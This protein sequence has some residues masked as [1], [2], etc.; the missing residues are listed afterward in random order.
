MLV[1]LF[2]APC[3]SYSRMDMFFLLYP[4]LAKPGI[5]FS[6][7]PLQNA[8]VEVVI[9]TRGHDHVAEVLSAL[10]AAGYAAR[11]DVPPATR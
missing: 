5:P 9:Q 3:H 2:Y 10:R 8:D 7:M 6:N 4:T 1:R 11:L